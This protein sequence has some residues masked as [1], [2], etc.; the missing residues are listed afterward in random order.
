MMIFDNILTPE[1]DPVFE[2]A[3]IGDI[4]GDPFEYM[5]N[6][7]YECA[8][9][10]SEIGLESIRLEYA[11][12][13]EYGIEPITESNIIVTVFEAIKKAITT[14]FTKIAEFFKSIFSS[15]ESSVSE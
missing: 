8:L 1:S 12:L 10:E 2:S 6:A 13:H 14:A 4:A 3:I 11:Y 5:L 9:M 7:S 15:S